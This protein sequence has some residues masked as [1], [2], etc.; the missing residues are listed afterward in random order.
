MEWS[1][2]KVLRK[3]YFWRVIVFWKLLIAH[4]SQILFHS[5][6]LFRT[7]WLR[8]LQNY[9][10]PSPTLMLKDKDVGDENDQHLKVVV[11]TFL[12]LEK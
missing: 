3:R 4:L 10:H 7:H 8:I 5:F 1:V 12:K 11:Y 6:W 9:P 2:D